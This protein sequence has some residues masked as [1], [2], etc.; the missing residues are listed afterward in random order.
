MRSLLDL[1]AEKE[2]EE[3]P[4]SKEELKEL[5]VEQKRQEILKGVASHRTNTIRDKVSWVLNHDPE[6]R[7]SDITLQLK[8]WETFESDIYTGGPIPPQNLYKLTRLTSLSRMRA[9]V[10][11]EYKL[12]LASNVIRER[13]GTLS[14]EEK[15]Q[16]VED[17]PN[18]PAFTVY[19]DDSGKTAKHLLI[20]SI[21][22]LA[23]YFAISKAILDIREEN[24]FDKE[25][26]F[27]EL[28]PV[29]L[30]IYKQAIDVFLKHA[31]AVSFKFISVLRAGIPKTSQS[32]TD[33]Y[34]HLLIRGVE[35]ENE[36][37]RAPLPRTLQVWI[38]T[39]EAELDKLRLANLKDR[40]YQASETYFDEQLNIDELHSVESKS[41]PILQIADLFVGSVN[42]ILNRSGSVHNHKDELAEYL[43]R[44]LGMEFSLSDNDKVGDMSFHI[45][46]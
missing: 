22:F 16:A 10:Q 31:N 27:K 3:E 19:M 33:L 29:Y 23:D 44:S 5:E 13:R 18:Y 30:P 36:T 40:L 4:L 25:F 8:Y 43:L 21:W 15:Q 9:K 11:N 26:H 45:T 17:K 35:H 7:D 28:K 12:F 20:G 24:N 32:L 41:S 2:S 39:E 14:E 46:L 1:I 34:Y 6:T 42:R 38:D 37:G